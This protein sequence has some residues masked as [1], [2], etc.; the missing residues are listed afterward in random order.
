LFNPEIYDIAVS[1]NDLIGDDF[2]VQDVY[3]L[4]RHVIEQFATNETLFHNIKAAFGANDTPSVK[5]F[6]RDS[7]T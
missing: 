7:N 1:L 4:H 2:T 5:E 3:N 6:E